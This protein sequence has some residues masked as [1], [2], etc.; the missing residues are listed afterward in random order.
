M[1]EENVRNSKLAEKRKGKDVSS[2]GL[3]RDIQAQLGNQLRQMYNDVV[4][5]GVP[6]KFVELLA[7]LEKTG[8]GE[9]EETPK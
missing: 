4:G 1:T 5:Q 6:K 8:S 7:K 3:D 2:V 9:K